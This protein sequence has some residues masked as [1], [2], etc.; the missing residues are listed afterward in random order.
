MTRVTTH[1]LDTSAGRPAAGVGFT[2]GDATGVT[3]A[4]GRALV[5]AD[6][7]PGRYELRFA[8]GAYFGDDAWLD[9]VPVRFGVAAG[10]DHVHVALLVTP[11]SY[12]T[13]RGS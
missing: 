7:A 1:V 11:W 9:V 3:D 10:W 13:Y 5:A 2:F 8:V 4:D 12:T 6:V